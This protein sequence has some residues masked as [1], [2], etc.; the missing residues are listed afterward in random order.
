MPEDDFPNVVVGYEQGTAY[1]YITD[2]RTALRLL[3]RKGQVLGANPYRLPGVP[4]GTERDEQRRAQDDFEIVYRSDA[5]HPIEE[6]ATAQPNQEVEAIPYLDKASL[7]RL[8]G[9]ELF[10]SD[11]EWE[12]VNGEENFPVS[13]FSPWD[14]EASSPKKGIFRSISKRI[15]GSF[16]RSAAP[17]RSDISAP[18]L[19]LR[20]EPEGPAGFPNVMEYAVPIEHP[21]PELANRASNVAEAIKLR[22]QNTNKLETK[23]IESNSQPSREQ[24][25]P[26][27]RPPRP[28]ILKVVG[29][30]DRMTELGDFIDAGL[31]DSSSGGLVDDDDSY[32]QERRILKIRSLHPLRN[33]TK[34]VDTSKYDWMPPVPPTLPMLPKVTSAHDW[35]MSDEYPTVNSLFDEINQQIADIGVQ[36]HELSAANH[37]DDR[38]QRTVDRIPSGTVDDE[39]TESEV[40]VKT[41]IQGDRTLWVA[42]ERPNERTA[43]STRREFRQEREGTAFEGDEAAALMARLRVLRK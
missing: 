11:D 3:T 13:R 7:A 15:K 9:I 26:P 33:P 29:E 19:D 10:P 35:R 8:E 34:R 23:P 36:D 12:Y 21:A 18:L 41:Y 16:R 40:M 25:E 42:T 32:D 20:H 1:P 14:S 24:A 43:H 6:E 31:A 37:G 27:K 39:D 17:A 30:E 38:L 28:H 4:D 22:R 5:L 2:R